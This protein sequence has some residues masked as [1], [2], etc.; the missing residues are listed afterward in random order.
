MVLPIIGGAA[1]FVARKYVQSKILPISEANEGENLV[2]EEMRNPRS[3][4]FK[5]VDEWTEGDKF[6][7][8]HSPSYQYNYY[9]QEKVKQYE[10]QIIDNYLQDWRKRDR[11]KGLIW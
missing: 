5:P 1:Q 7:A 8:E 9:L 4:M 2:I 11:L 10:D 6:R 3:P